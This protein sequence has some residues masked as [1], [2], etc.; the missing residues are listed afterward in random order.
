M[1]TQ[2]QEILKNVKEIKKF[3]ET[4]SKCKKYSEIIET[5]DEQY[6]RLNAMV[7]D[8]VNKDNIE[9]QQE[10][11]RVS[12]LNFGTKSEYEHYMKEKYKTFSEKY[13]NIFDQIIDG[14]LR[15]DVL[16]DCLMT[17]SQVK[18]GQMTFSQGYNHGV[19]YLTDKDKLP[20]NFLNR[21]PESQTRKKK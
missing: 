11:G 20:S 10:F 3:I 14:S 18:R 9:L 8:P 6:K 2:F 19:D 12:Q 17:G 1:D 7:Q 15:M 5:T 21:M 16:E 13:P 4:D